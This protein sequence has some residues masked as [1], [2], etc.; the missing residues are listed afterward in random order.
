MNKIRTI[1]IEV[2]KWAYLL[3]FFLI[4]VL[5]LIWLILTSFKTEAEFNT[6]PLALPALWQFQ[7]Y[8]NAVSVAN[9]HVLFMNSIIIATTATLLNLFVT[10]LASFVISREEF[11]FRQSVSNVIVAGVLMPIVAFMVPYLTIIRNLG[12]Y[13]TRMALVITYAAINIP[14]SFFL[15]KSFMVNIP[16]DL[17]DAAII[18][19]CTFAQRYTKVVLPLSRS[20][21]VTAGTLTFIW[22]WN[23]FIYALLLTSSSSVR[24]IQLGI[25]FFTTQFRSDY[26]SMYAAVVLTMIPSIIVYVFFHDKIISGLTAGA[27]KG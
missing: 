25:S 17:E 11:A 23:E 4:A 24:T 2:F 5:P 6:A 16:K 19:G 12:L 1:V 20:G 3:F 27:V 7:N 10:S 13:D 14:I 26:P 18:D 22:A 15:I 8:I 21:L 9:M